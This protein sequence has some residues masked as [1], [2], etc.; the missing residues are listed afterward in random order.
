VPARIR[1]RVPVPV[2]DG[3]SCAVQLA[4]ARLALT[5]RAPDL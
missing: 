2:L 5:R 4:S 3:L 1:D